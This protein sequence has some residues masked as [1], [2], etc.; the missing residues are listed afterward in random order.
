VPQPTVRQ[1]QSAV[2]I[3]FG[4]TKAEL[5]GNSRCYRLTH[6]RAL[7]IMLAKE[8]T[9]ASYPQ[10]GRAFDGR[11]HSTVM[12]A[13]KRAHNLIDAFPH[14]YDKVQAVKQ[15]LQIQP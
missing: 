11:H 2:A 9:G 10:L 15:L 5:T 8:L 3:A 14:Y 13:H 7:A 4:I 1:I 12:H 6:P